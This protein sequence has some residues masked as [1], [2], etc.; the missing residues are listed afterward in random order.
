MV[1]QPNPDEGPFDDEP[2]GDDH[3]DAATIPTAEPTPRPKKAPFGRQDQRPLTGLP[4][5]V[6]KRYLQGNRSVYRWIGQFDEWLPDKGAVL[7]QFGGGKFKLECSDGGR[8]YWEIAERHRPVG[9]APTRPA[10]A[11]A[12]PAF[13]R[14]PEPT[15]ESAQLPLLVA[16]LHRGQ[17]QLLAMVARIEGALVGMAARLDAIDHRAAA[18]PPPPAPAPAPVMHAPPPSLL[19]QI[20]EIAALKS[21]LED[22]GIMGGGGSSADAGDSSE[23]GW[24]AGAFKQGL[25]QFASGA[26]GGGMPGPPGPRAT[27][28]SVPPVGVPRAH[29][30][31][32]PVA[33]VAAVA[34]VAPAPVAQPARHA[35]PTLAGSTPELEDQFDDIA[36]A[37]GYTPEQA[38]H[39]ALSQGWSLP[40]AVSYGRAM[41]DEPVDDEPEP[42]LVGQP[43]PDA[44]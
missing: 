42:D 23:W 32:P 43:G 17:G 34:A 36:G 26:M 5:L 29:P 20:Q 44:P 6:S 18:P 39:Y 24:L 40:E 27:L 28:A 21:G 13:P 3:P 4:V 37:L 2:A 31:A 35:G 22:L 12:P 33:P 25:Q 38:R 41:L 9:P 10:P 8:Q 30:T 11:A 1:A 19:H 16:Q 15:Q 14:R 7:Q